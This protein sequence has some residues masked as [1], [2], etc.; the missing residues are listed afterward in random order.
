MR[1]LF[2]D[3]VD[4][5]VDRDATQQLAVNVDD[6]RGHEVAVLEE[7]RHFVRVGFGRDTRGFVIDDVADGL[8]RIL[9]D[10]ARERDGAEIAVVAVDNE[11]PVGL[12][13]QFRAHAQV[14]QHDFHGDVGA[15]AHRVGVHE[16]A[17]G[18]RL[19]REDGVEALAV[20]SVHGLDDLLHHG[21]GQVAHQ[22]REVVDLHALGRGEQVLGI[23][24]LDE[25]LAYLV[26]EFDQH[27]AL[28]LG[29][30]E[31]PDDLALRGWQRFDQQRDLRRVHRGDHARRSAPRT[32]TQRA[33][34]GGEPTFLRGCA[35]GVDH[36]AREC[37]GV[38]PHCL[39]KGGVSQG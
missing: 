16:A 22:V 3:D 10:E 25:R 38:R 23:H 19:E 15:H 14:T 7:S 1:S 11:Q 29:L 36:D 33:A 8:F 35:G 28:D 9:G 24:P 2:A 13:R 34:Q 27:V 31:I 18:I 39:E 20:L 17:G 26:G 30:D 37:I 21:F 12:V 6:C 5:V 32:F 4:H